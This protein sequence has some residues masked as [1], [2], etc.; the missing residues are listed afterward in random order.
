MVKNE[1]A[2][3]CSFQFTFDTFVVTGGAASLVVLSVFSCFGAEHRLCEIVSFGVIGLELGAIIVKRVLEGW[4]WLKPR[5]FGIFVAFSGMV[6]TALSVWL[7]VNKFWEVS[8]PAA[9]FLVHMPTSLI[10]ACLGGLD[11]RFKSIA[12]FNPSPVPLAKARNG[13]SV[14]KTANGAGGDPKEN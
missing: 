8:P 11:V 9:V 1:G 5:P 13:N 4:Y 2:G 10:L 14:S 7:A 12:G 3:S 6:P